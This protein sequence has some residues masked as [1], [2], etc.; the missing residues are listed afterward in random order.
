[1]DRNI[2]YPG[3]IPLDTDVLT[4]QRNTLIAVGHLIYSL[5]GGDTVAD[6]MACTPTIPAS[7]AVDVAAGSL[8][9]ASTVDATAYGAMAADNRFLPKMGINLSGTRFSV[10]PPT[11]AGQS[12]HYLVQAAMVEADGVPVVLPY[13]NAANPG[14]AFSGPGNSAVAQNTVRTQQVSLQLKPGAPAPTGTQVTPAVDPGAVGLWV[15]RVSQGQLSILSADITMYPTAPFLRNRLHTLSSGVPRQTVFTTSGNWT[16]P[17]GVFSLKARLV[18]GGGGGGSGDPGWA[19]GGG[20]AGGYVES[21]MTVTPGQLIPLTVGAGGASASGRVSGVAG[22]TTSFGSS[23]SATGGGGGGSANTQSPGGPGG[24]GFNGAL[25]L[26]GGYGGDG[27]V[28]SAGI[29]GNGGA[30]AFGGGGRGA[31]G[32]GIFANGQAPGSGGGGGYRDPTP[33]GT[34]ANGIIIV[35]Y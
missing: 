22:G 31:S 25:S 35:E 12:M 9:A 15:V 11:A 3:A 20:G 32:G 6:G 13:Y 2:V 7:L 24:Q 33:G 28:T 21:A 8:T 29:G 27:S 26:A 34:G 1:M 4:I 19:G 17:P 30:S 16:V 18:G 5:Y 23:L 14:Q 10:T